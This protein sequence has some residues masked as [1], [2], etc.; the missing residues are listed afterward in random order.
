MD[1]SG[2]MPKNQSSFSLARVI[3]L[4]VPLVCAAL[5][6]IWI[7]TRQINEAAGEAQKNDQQSMRKLFHLD[8]PHGHALD[9]K[10]IDEDH[11]LVA[12]PPKD[13]SKQLHPDTLVFSYV[14]GPEA[15][16]ELPDWKDFVRFL[17]DETGKPVKARVFESTEDQLRALAAGK[18][19]VT[20]F[21][22]GN[23][24][25]AV[26]S[27]GFVPV[28][29]FGREDGTFGYTMQF[30]V[31]ANSAIKSIADLKGHTIT[32]TTSG[33]NSGCKAALALLQE[34][35]LQPL[36]DY[37]WKF[38][39]DHL[40]SVKWIINGEAEVAPVASELLQRKIDQGEIKP[41]QFRVIYQS[42]RYPPATM[43]YVYN[44]SEDLTAKIRAAFLDFKPKGTS[45]EKRMQA[46][47]SQKFVPV[48]YKQDF[49]LVRQIDAAFRQTAGN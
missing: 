10:F 11:D 5:L 8:T 6:F 47:S 43:G 22:T 36:R 3:V 17:E 27:A 48:S 25:E 45:M 12:D 39:G 19:H 23:V 2:D 37:T 32:F 18:L 44:L 41:E 26:N 40:E 49:A 20:G 4:G 42:E 34:N 29:T 28:C 14:A 30:I 15:E 21:N 7:W 1:T 13:K 24:P 16:N 33:S 46:A 38:S 31:P 9:P 35:D